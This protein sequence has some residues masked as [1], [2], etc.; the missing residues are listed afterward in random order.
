ML[1]DSLAMAFVY[2]IAGLVGL[3]W[4]A[5]RFIVG[6]AAL[7]RTLGVP[8]LLVGIV[9]VGFGTSAPEL[10]VSGNAAWRGNPGLAIGN[11]LGS[12][13]ANVALVLGA[14]ALAAPLVI[15]S[16]ILW[17]EVPLTFAAMLV[18]GVVIHDLALGRVESIL[19]LCF[20]GL[21]LALLVIRGRRERGD[22]LSRELEHA[23]PAAG[24]V[25]WSVFWTIAGLLVLLLSSHVLVAGAVDIAHAFNVSDLV[26]G[27]TIVA[28]GTSLPEAAAAL[29]SARRNEPDIAIGNVLG[30]NT[31]NMLGVIGVAG[32]IQ[33]S[34]VEPDAL[35][36]D[37]P[38]MMAAFILFILLAWGF[39]RITRLHGLLFLAAYGGY[40][41]Y[42][43]LGA[44]A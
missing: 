31:F 22:E 7:A 12:N 9:I 5:D 8:V 41:A 1:S 34:A 17:Q 3:T 19:M 43:G 36:R 23:I 14:A 2:V 25:G 38:V 29:A 6:T 16:R 33:P 37:W 27:L 20:L 11:A 28:V 44:T 32:V 30:S 15:R 4:S 40:L 24:A 13:I 18:A 39:K 26:I 42:L 21:F 35:Y 10:L